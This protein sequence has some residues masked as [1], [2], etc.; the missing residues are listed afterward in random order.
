MKKFISVILVI[1]AV[2]ALGASFVSC[3]SPYSDEELISIFK[4]QYEKSFVLNEYIWGDGI[5]AIEYDPES[6]KLDY[7]YVEVANDAE[8]T[9]KISFIDA[10]KSVYVSDFVSGEINQLLFTGYGD[11]GPEPRYGEINGR[12]SINVL[13]NGNVNIG[14]GRFLPETARVKKARGSVVVFTVTYERDGNKNDYD[15]MMRLEDGVW[16]FEAPTY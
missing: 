14:G 11:D 15:L 8:Y 16:K 5:P 13:D 6:I 7:Y 9:T 12:L 1:A 3:S 4:T 10:I 2:M